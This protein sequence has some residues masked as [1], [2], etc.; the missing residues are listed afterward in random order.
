M[1]INLVTGEADTT[2]LKKLSREKLDGMAE[3]LG[4]DPTKFKN[5]DEL[6][7]C[8]R[9]VAKVHAEKT[10]IQVKQKKLDAPE[11]V[12]LTTIACDGEYLIDTGDTNAEGYPVHRCRL[13]KNLQWIGDNGC[14]GC[15]A[16][17]NKLNREQREAIVEKNKG[18]D[19]NDVIEAQN[20]K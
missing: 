14:V 9:I 11:I 5:V 8:I 1:S 20:P 6:L 2:K 4:I 12:E 16:I 3:V 13:R 7:E 15:E 17:H 10:D 19:A 18:K